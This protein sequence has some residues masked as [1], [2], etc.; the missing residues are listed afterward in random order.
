MMSFTDPVTRQPPPTAQRP[1]QALRPQPTKGAAL[2]GLYN[3]PVAPARGDARRPSQPQQQP[4]QPTQRLDPRAQWEIDAETARLKAQVEAEAREQRRQADIARRAR[5]KADEEEERKT[6]QFL[7]NE[8]RKRKQEEADRRRRQVEVE[9]ETERLRRQFGDQSKLL[10][11]AQPQQRHSAPLIQGQWQRPA[12]APM[13]GPSHR[14]SASSGPYLQPQGGPRPAASQS[15][16]FSNGL[17][18]PNAQAQQKM[19]KK[20][21][22][23]LRTSSETNTSTL[24]KKQSSMF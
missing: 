23:G 8:D 14:P 16:F 4:N 11:P 10:P 20:S 19:K 9:R 18:K 2:N 12:P 22:W 17:P 24:R 3:Q 1:T 6:R 15:A 13:A 7:E 5:R 21:F